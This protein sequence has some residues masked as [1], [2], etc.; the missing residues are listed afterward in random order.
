MQKAAIREISLNLIFHG[1]TF[2]E[3][4]LDTLGNDG[5]RGNQDVAMVRCPGNRT[6]LLIP[7]TAIIATMLVQGLSCNL[8]GQRRNENANSIVGRP[9][10]G[11]S[12]PQIRKSR[13]VRIFKRAV[14]MF[15]HVS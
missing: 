14:R 15:H 7:F 4:L 2:S 9:Q 11:N 12:F 8:I 6:G 3:K 5:F 10:F 13:I 1:R